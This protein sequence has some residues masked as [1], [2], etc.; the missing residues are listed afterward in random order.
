MSNRIGQV[1]PGHDQAAFTARVTHAK[2]VSRN[3]GDLVFDIV[4][5][6]GGR[7]VTIGE[8]SK[9]QS[10]EPIVVVSQNQQKVFYTT[11]SE[12][13]GYE[14]E[15]EGIQAYDT[16]TGKTSTILKEYFMIDDVKEVKHG[17]RSFLLVGMSDGG[18]GASHCAI[19]DVERG[20]VYSQ[21][22]A[23]I[24]TSDK[25]S[26]RIAVYGDGEMFDEEGFIKPPPKTIE[27]KFADLRK[28]KVIT[29]E[30]DWC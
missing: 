22:H 29:N 6:I 30:P 18:E 3:D 9:F 14:N 12:G 11:A 7:K 2:A 23:V 24:M 16:H 8:S 28:A 25:D 15:G 17:D 19:V 26:V 1:A 5:T 20:E 10:N 27:V 13:Y 4:A 21:D